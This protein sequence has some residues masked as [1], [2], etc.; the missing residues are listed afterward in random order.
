MVKTTSSPM[1]ALRETGSKSSV[2]RFFFLAVPLL[3]SLYLLFSPFSL[4]P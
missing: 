4:P 2:V 1:D 3:L